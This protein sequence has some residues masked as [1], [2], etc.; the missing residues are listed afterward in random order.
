MLRAMSLRS[1]LDEARRE[2]V[3]EQLIGKV[4]P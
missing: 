3:E 1:M 2:G 4:Q